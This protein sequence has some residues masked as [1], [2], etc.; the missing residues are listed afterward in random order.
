MMYPDNEVGIIISLVVYGGAGLTALPLMNELVVESTYPVGEATST[1]FAMMMSQ[2]R[3]LFE[4][5][6]KSFEGYGRN[7]CGIKSYTADR[8]RTRDF[9]LPRGSRAKLLLVYG[10]AQRFIF[11]VL[12]IFSVF[13]RVRL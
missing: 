12:S 6:L 1:G 2:V 3:F 4:I 5:N 13:L 8:I 11:T 9:S 7:I 10:C